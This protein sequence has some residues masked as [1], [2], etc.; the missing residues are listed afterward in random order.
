MRELLTDTLAYIPPARALESLPADAADRRIA[1]ASH[2]IAEIVAHVAFWQRWF[3]ARCEGVDEPMVTSAANGWPGV[4][5]GSWNEVA[6]GFLADLDRAAALGDDESRLDRLVTPAIQ[7]PPIAS[8]TIRDA[9]VHVATH[10]AHHLGQVIV[11]RQMMGLWPPPS[12]AWT[13]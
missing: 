9:L 12:G 6:A 7:F 3:L 8:Y 2:S 5:P 13:W 4:A 11:L 1:G 10:N